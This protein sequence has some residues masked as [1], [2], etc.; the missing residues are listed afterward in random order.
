[1]KTSYSLNESSPLNA[2]RWRAFLVVGKPAVVPM[3]PKA[4]VVPEKNIPAKREN[5]TKSIVGP[6]K[7]E[8][9]GWDGA[10]RPQ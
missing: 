6:S 4:L 5:A 3:V 2:K 10:S 7:D 1:M 8:Y 9:A